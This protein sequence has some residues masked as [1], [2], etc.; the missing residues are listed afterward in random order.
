MHIMLDRRQVL[1]IAAAA[2][3]HTGHRRLVGQMMCYFRN[4][5]FRI[6]TPSRCRSGLNSV[7]KLFC[8]WSRLLNARSWPKPAADSVC[9]RH[10]GA[11]NAPPVIP[12]NLAYAGS[13]LPRSLVTRKAWVAAY[14]I[15]GKIPVRCDRRKRVSWRKTNIAPNSMELLIRRRPKPEA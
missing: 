14:R 6:A 8:T 11:I 1:G 4:S 10:T 15:R 9:L 5:F 7:N 2:R 3:L 12:A 13:T